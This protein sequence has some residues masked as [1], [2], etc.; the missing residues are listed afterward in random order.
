MGTK[1]EEDEMYKEF[2]YILSKTDKEEDIYRE[3]QRAINTNKA[4]TCAAF[5]SR[6]EDSMD[7][8]NQI[9]DGLKG[10]RIDENA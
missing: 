7:M 9:L 4:P 1:E 2:A 10:I 8:Q 3:F 5:I 6:A